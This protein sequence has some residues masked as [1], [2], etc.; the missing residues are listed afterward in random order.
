MMQTDELVAGK[1]AG[2]SARPAEYE[3]GRRDMLLEIV[4]LLRVMVVP[5]VLWQSVLAR[6]ADRI[7]ARYRDG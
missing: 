5:E 3:R 7:E 1:T 2:R 4:A 6:A